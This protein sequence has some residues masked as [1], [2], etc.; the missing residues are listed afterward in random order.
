[1]FLPGTWCS[2]HE[3]L[4]SIP[5][6]RSQLASENN[7][8]SMAARSSQL[9]IALASTRPACWNLRL[10]RANTAK[11]GIP[12]TLYR[13]ASSG[14]RSVSTLS[15]MARPARSRAT[16]A[17][18]GAAIRQ[19]P[20]QAAQKSTRT[21]TLLSRTNSSNSSGLT[22]MGS[23]I[24]G[25]AALQAPHLP[26]SDRCFAGIRF[27]FPQDWQ[28]RMMAMV[29]PLINSFPNSTSYPRRIRQAPAILNH[30]D[31][32]DGP[33]GSRNSGI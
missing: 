1:M 4:I 10:P 11:F 14:D 8:S 20:H 22:S 5:E 3:C 25:N 2:S 23:A 29:C 24:A 19:G 31:V 26:I 28:F 9:F 12:R 32:L 6:R 18:C 21:G 27:G 17:T 7:H 30:S 16:C 15:T 13:E 33:G